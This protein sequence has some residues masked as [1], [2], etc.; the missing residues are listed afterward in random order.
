MISG[1][2][3]GFAVAVFA[4]FFAVLTWTGWLDE[5]WRGWLLLIAGLPFSV[6]AAHAIMKHDEQLRG[7]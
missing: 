5:G 4:A 1:L 7:R 3:A 2:K 6:W